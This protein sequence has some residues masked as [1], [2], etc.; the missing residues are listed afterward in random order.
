MSDTKALCIALAGRRKSSKMKVLDN[1]STGV[2]MSYNIMRTAKIKDRQAITSAASHNFRIRQQ[3]NIDAS[4]TPLNRVL[5]NP[6]KVD[7]RKADALQKRSRADM[8]HWE[9]KSGKLGFGTRVHTFGQS[10]V[11]RRTFRRKSRDLGRTSGKVYE[12]E[13]GDNLQI[14]VLHLDEKTPHLHFLLS[15]EEKSLKRYKTRKESS[16]VKNTA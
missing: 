14:A 2:S 10:R 11:F 7:L 9:R 15:C 5:W 12:N 4:R 13:F 1:K 16:S 8:R 3:G 6:M